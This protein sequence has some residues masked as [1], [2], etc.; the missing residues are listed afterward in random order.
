MWEAEE[1]IEFP[2]RPELEELKTG[3]MIKK[4]APGWDE[5]TPSEV[6]EEPVEFTYRPELANVNRTLGLPDGPEL[7]E[8]MAAEM[9]KEE[10][11]GWDEFM[12]RKVKEERVKSTYRP[13]LGDVNRTRGL[14]D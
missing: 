12:P 8:L 2:S 13:E 3:E 11:P 4:E 1:P 5:F 14:P 9:I 10:A 7:E 6:K